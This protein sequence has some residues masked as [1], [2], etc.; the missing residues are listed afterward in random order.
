MAR[1][2][3]AD[4]DYRMIED[5]KLAIDESNRTAVHE[6]VKSEV[7]EELQSDIAQHT[8]KDEQYR[9][10][11]TALGE[12]MREKTLRELAG[13]EREIDRGRAAARASQVVDYI[14]FIIYALLGLE[15]LLELLGARDGSPFKH[16]I[17][18]L[19]LP[20]LMPFQRL[21]PDLGAGRFQLRLSYIIAFVVYILLHVAV[22]GLL[23]MLAHR[24]TAI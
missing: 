11:T 23:R 22:N 20:F 18:V 21:M 14:F 24:K 6:G 1:S 7:R 2:T 3:S 12:G 8:P 16:L 10:Q 17:D 4:G 15:I 13:T 5:N 19:T 9:A